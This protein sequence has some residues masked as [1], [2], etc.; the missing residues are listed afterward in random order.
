MSKL[1]DG[2]E[3]AQIDFGHQRRRLP[4]S[5]MFTRVSAG[6][7]AGIDSLSSVG[8]LAHR[9]TGM[10]GF[11]FC[12]RDGCSVTNCLVD[13]LACDAVEASRRVSLTTKGLKRPERVGDVL[14]WEG[15]VE[16]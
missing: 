14:V 5:K 8:L 11:L 2:G 3:P 4:L 12:G 16:Y 7:T 1:Q 9:I 10:A 13:R 6:V 15:V